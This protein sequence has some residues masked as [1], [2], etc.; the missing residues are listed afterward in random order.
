MLEKVDYSILCAD[1]D[2]VTRKMLKEML[3]ERGYR[4]KI[5]SNGSQILTEA[6]RSHYDLIL[7]D[8]KMPVMD[9]L[10][11]ARRVRSHPNT[12]NIPIIFISAHHEEEDIMKCLQ[13]G[14]NHFVRKPIEPAE[15]LAKIAF[16]L[17]KHGET[18]ESER[19]LP[20]GAR[21][22][23]RYEILQMIDSGGFSKIYKAVDVTDSLKTVY[24]LKVFD[25][26]F[27]KR[28]N[29][30]SLYTILR[31]A[32]QLTKLDHP[33]IV[34][35]HDF[36]QFGSVIFLVLEYIDG[37]PLDIFVKEK[38]ALNEFN[39]AFIGFEMAS[40]LEYMDSRN[41]THR[42]IKPDNMM[43]TQSGDVKLVDFGL[44]KQCREQTLS[45]K[46]DEFQGTAKYVSPE[47]AAGQPADIRSDLYSLG[48]SLYYIATGRTPFEGK[49]PRK[50]LCQ[51]AQA[52]PDSPK[53][54]RPELSDAFCELVLKLLA[55]DPDDRPK[56]H[57]V[58]LALA[59]ILSHAHN[60]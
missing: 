55:K 2:P 25:F 39:C 10:E 46:S 36:G 44:A 51:H 33:C 15:L 58:R 3:E 49:D 7:L 43:I 1:D 54:L 56:A 60:G 30:Q 53:T 26:P 45:I 42:D 28:S 29:L 35:I 19:G 34:K 13:V 21:L 24:A 9:G 38:G 12:F 14:G 20:P 18:F 37:Q 59:D 27:T 17:K 6:K 16:T 23:G 11:A 4:V 31:E 50:I 41:M 40:V 57:D 48:I 22:A 5:V 47:C 32:Y 52:I 8:Y